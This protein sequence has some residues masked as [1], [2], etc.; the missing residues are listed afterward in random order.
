[1]NLN[2]Y[3]DISYVEQEDYLEFYMLDPYGW[4]TWYVASDK[5]EISP[6][7]YMGCEFLPG[8]SVFLDKETDYIKRTTD[9]FWP[10]KGEQNE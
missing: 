4:H 10:S 5:F 3:S 6:W 8:G 9:G 2:P 7:I 1:M